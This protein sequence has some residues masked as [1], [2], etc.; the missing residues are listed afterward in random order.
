MVI[1]N[2]TVLNSVISPPTSSVVSVAMLGTWLVTVLTARGAAIGATLEVSIR[3]A[4]PSAVVML[5]TE[6]WR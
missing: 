1:A 3:A 2:T 6:K 5:L 4:E